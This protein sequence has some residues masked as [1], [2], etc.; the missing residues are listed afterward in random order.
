MLRNRHPA[1]RLADVRAEIKRLKVEEEAIRAELAGV[2]D[3]ARQGVEWTATVNGYTQQ[4]LDLKA[5]TAA[6]GEDA[7]RP[8]MRRRVFRQVRLRRRPAAA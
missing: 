2:P 1:D 5:A 7:L 6:L 3:T 8:F 4:R